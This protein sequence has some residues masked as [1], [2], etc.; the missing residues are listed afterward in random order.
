MPRNAKVEKSCLVCGASFH[1]PHCRKDT[2][3]TCSDTCRKAYQQGAGNPNWKGGLVACNCQNCGKE[4][5]VK[6]GLAEKQKYC[7]YDCR[8]ANFKM[9]SG[10]E[11]PNWNGEVERTKTCKQCGKL[12]EWSGQRLRTWQTRVF[13]SQTCSIVG[14]ARK[15][16]LKEL[17]KYG[18]LVR[19]WSNLVVARDNGVCQ[20]CGATGGEMH[21]H[22]IKPVE[23]FP[24]LT[25]EL[26]NGMTLCGT[27]HLALHK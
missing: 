10:E 21:A 8:F 14:Q 2:A 13:C 26:S 11:N 7:S 18:A 24:E 3:K 20:K 27:C 6:P 9:K 19:S 17:P 5:Q 23:Q 15:G 25:F 22:H 16:V 12:F 4:F 1:V